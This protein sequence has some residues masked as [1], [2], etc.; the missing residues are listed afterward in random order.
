M[1]QYDE[2]FEKQRKGTATTE[3][4]PIVKKMNKGEELTEEDLVGYILMMA[5]GIIE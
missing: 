5:M 3:D 2:F 4:I 1:D